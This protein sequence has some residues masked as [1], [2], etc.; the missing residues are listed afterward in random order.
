MWFFART[1][2]T[3]FVGYL[4]QGQ[5]APGHPWLVSRTW[6]PG[7]APGLAAQDGK[8]SKSRGQ[9]ASVRPVACSSAWVP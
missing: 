4:V 5:P 7:L 1:R 2:F 3:P 8:F 9:S 6:P